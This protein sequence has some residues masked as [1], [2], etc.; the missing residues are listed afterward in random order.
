MV[1]MLMVFCRVYGKLL[2]AWSIRQIKYTITL[3]KCLLLIQSYS[4]LEKQLDG[5]GRGPRKQPLVFRARRALP[6]LVLR[7]AVTI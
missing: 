5:A 7:E 1:L 6:P 3:R 4:S 2:G